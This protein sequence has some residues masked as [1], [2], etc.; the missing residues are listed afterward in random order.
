MHLIQD[1]SFTNLQASGEG[2][3]AAGDAAYFVDP[4][5]SSGVFMAHMTG[6]RAAYTI[7]TRWRRDDRRFA[8]LCWRD[9]NGFVQRLSGAFIQMALYWYSDGHTVRRWC[10]LAKGFLPGRR[11]A[12]V[13]RLRAFVQLTTGLAPYHSGILDNQSYWTNARMTLAILA[14]DRSWRLERPTARAHPRNWRPR[15][16]CRYKIVESVAMEPGTG[17]LRPDLKLEFLPFGGSGR[18]DALRPLVS[19]GP[20]H[21]AALEQFAKRRTVDDA[22]RACARSG[23]L[24]EPE[25][26]GFVEAF[27]RVLKGAG[28]VV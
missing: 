13:S 8:D 21:L 1:Y 12:E 16:R 22:V 10:D 18:G 28:Y 19:V 5:I 23:S 15:L 2:W 4:I 26:H 9:Y 27:L 3:I 20:A 11:D 17:L 7:G 14:E 25:A 6:M 24:S